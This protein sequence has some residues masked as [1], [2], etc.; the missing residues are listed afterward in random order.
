MKGD[1]HSVPV[2]TTCSREIPAAALVHVGEDGEVLDVR[3]YA[4]TGCPPVDAAAEQAA[5]SLTFTPAQREGRPHRS[6]VR[7]QLRSQP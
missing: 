6:W 7:L 2:C 1:V 3:L 4:S 5:R